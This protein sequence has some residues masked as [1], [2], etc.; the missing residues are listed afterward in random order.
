[1]NETKELKKETF[2]RFLDSVDQELGRDE[3][4]LHLFEWVV[5]ERYNRMIDDSIEFF[6]ERPDLL[7][8]QTEEIQ[9]EIELLLRYFESIEEYEKCSRILKIKEEIEYTIKGL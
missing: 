9:W 1:M 4:S 7:A 3:D 6:I 5:E 8:I 2:D